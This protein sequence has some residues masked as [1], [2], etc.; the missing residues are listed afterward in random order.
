[1][2][3]TLAGI[4]MIGGA[5]AASVP[6]RTPWLGSRYY[7]RLRGRGQRR[8]RGQ[9]RLGGW[10]DRAPMTKKER[11]KVAKKCGSRCFAGPN[12]SYPMCSKDSRV[13]GTDCMG[14]RAA[15][16]RARQYKKPKIA[17]KAA[18]A[19]KK[20]GCSWVR[21]KAAQSVLKRGR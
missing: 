6:T 4:A 10:D 15:F 20:A 14:A 2:N 21:G 9:S 12:R 3:L 11:A 19:G 1:M 8:P 5:F 18:K 16:S 13:C 7:A 17:L